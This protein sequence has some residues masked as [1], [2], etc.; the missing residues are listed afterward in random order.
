[1]LVPYLADKLLKHVLEGNDTRNTAVLVGDEDDVLLGALQE[2]HEVLQLHIFGNEGRLLQQVIDCAL[3]GM[4]KAEK[5]LLVDYANDVV[6][7]LVID[8]QTGEARFKKDR[9]N[10]I[11]ITAVFNGDH[12]DTRGCDLACGGIAELNCTADKLAL[13]LVDSALLLGRFNEGD[14]L[15]LADGRLCAVRTEYAG[16]KLGYLD[17]QEY[18]RGKHPHYH[19]ENRRGKHCKFL[20]R[21]LSDTFG[22]YLS[23][24][25][26]GHR[27]NHRRERNAEITE[28]VDKQHRRQRGRQDIDDIVSY[29]YGAEQSVKILRKLQRPCG[30]LVTARLHTLHSNATHRCKCRLAGREK[31]AHQQQNTQGKYKINTTAP[32]VCTQRSFL[33]LRKI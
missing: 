33:R 12:V 5:V 6:K 19:P 3:L 1:M 23:E 32:I 10:G 2:L 11:G 17:Q 16:N 26:D 21:L 14:D 4:D 13:L 15:I 31:G 24:D 22:R 7:A 8:G 29:K 27:H 20:G 25:D 18:Y 9:R 30:A 28:P